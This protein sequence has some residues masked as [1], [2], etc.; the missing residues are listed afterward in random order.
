MGS[1]R[2]GFGLAISEWINEKWTFFKNKKRQKKRK[3]TITK[4]KKK[5]R[6]DG[7]RANS[8]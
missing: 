4:N 3:K 1:M 8:R 2:V 7:N 6:S 5:R